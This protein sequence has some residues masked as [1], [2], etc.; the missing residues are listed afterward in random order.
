M[1][2]YIILEKLKQLSPIHFKITST[3]INVRDIFDFV[4]KDNKHAVGL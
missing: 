3:V 1:Y 2:Q 4:P